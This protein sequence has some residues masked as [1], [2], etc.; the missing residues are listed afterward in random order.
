MIRQ[1]NVRMGK[2]SVARTT[3]SAYHQGFACAIS[4]PMTARLIPRSAK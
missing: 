4:R 1:R 3:D 2:V